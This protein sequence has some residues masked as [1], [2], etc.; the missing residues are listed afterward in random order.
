MGYLNIITPPEIVDAKSSG[1]VTV[2]EGSPASLRCVAEGS[3]KPVV[4]WQREDGRSISGGGATGQL[5]YNA[6]LF[7]VFFIYG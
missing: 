1:D 4:T 5:G 3:P 6:N 7:P 2:R